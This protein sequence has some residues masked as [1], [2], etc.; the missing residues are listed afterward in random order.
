VLA[1]LAGRFTL[2]AY[3]AGGEVRYLEFG[4]YRQAYKLGAAKGLEPLGLEDPMVAPVP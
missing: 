4:L 3:V 2:D 1:G